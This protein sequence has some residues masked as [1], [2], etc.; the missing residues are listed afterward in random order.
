[1][2]GSPINLYVLSTASLPFQKSQERGQQRDLSFDRSESEIMQ[3]APP[4][5]LEY[6]TEV[7]WDGKSG[8]HARF[9]DSIQGLKHELR[10]DKPIEFGGKGDFPSPC[11][12]F[13]TGFGSCLLTT[14][15][16]MKERMRLDIAGLQVTVKATV[17]SAMVGGYHLDGIEAII[18]VETNEENKAKAERCVAL[19]SSYSFALRALKAGVPINVGSDIKIQK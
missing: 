10:V 16:Y 9:G 8:G 18:H 6:V 14:F 1:M 19:T 11:S 17:R 7:S 4:S 15:L 5:Q 12:V 13:F 2:L 3:A